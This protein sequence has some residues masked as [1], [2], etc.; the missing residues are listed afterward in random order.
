MNDRDVA[1]VPNRQPDGP[2]FDHWNNPAVVGDYYIVDCEVA[3]EA[4]SA[5]IDGEREPVPSIRVDE[6]LEECSA[7]RS[8]FERANVQ[9]GQLRRAARPRP[10]IL[11]TGPFGRTG[12]AE[13]ERRLSWQRWALLGVGVV[14]VVVAG[15]QALGLSMGLMGEHGMSSGHH[16][17]NESTAWSIALGVVMIGAAVRPSGAAGLAGVLGVF[18]AVLAVY[19]ISDAM[20]G[21]VTAVRIVSHVP[22]V[23]GAILAVM[24]WRTSSHPRPAPDAVAAEPDIVLPHNASR[25]RRR[26]HLWPTDGSAA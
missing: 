7:C 16:L 8:W 4:L 14:Q 12:G 22:V 21:A 19:V 17:V 9:A 15:V 26:G 18:T 13:P 10:T 25:G 6:H 24:V 20:S 11:P 5:R 2:V 23:L 3:R 1:I